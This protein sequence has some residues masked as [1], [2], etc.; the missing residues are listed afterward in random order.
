[1]TVPKK[2]W[3]V[4]P[5]GGVKGVFQIGFLE[6]FLSTHGEQYAVDR[7]YG[8]SVGAIMS[9]LVASGK[10]KEMYDIMSNIDDITDVFEP[11]NWFENLVKIIPLFTKLAM[12]RRVKLI[13]KVTSVLNKLPEKDRECA[14][15]KCQVVAWDMLNKEEVWFSGKDLITGMK[16]SS[17]LSLVVPPIKYENRQLT[18]GWVTELIPV[19]RMISDLKSV[20]QE[21]QEN[22]VVLIV[23]CGTRQPKKLTKLPTDPVRFSLELLGDSSLQLTLTELH[24]FINA[25]PALEIHYIK[26]EREGFDSSIDFDKT[27]IAQVYEAAKITG[28][29]TSLVKNT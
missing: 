19:T 14:M 12:F 1:M 8:T 22:I 7:V 11:W 27:K 18:D 3:V 24:D 5:G 23:D 10:F 15:G 28:F 21:E 9:P 6:G 13:D 4:L 26:P 16:A 2:L 29:N 25:H 17:A 20:T